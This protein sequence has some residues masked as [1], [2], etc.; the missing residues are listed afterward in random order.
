MVSDVL[1]I[2][3]LNRLQALFG[4]DKLGTRISIIVLGDFYQLKPIRAS[5]VFKSKFWLENFLFIELD[6]NWRSKD[7]PIYTALLQRIR[8]GV[9]TED[10]KLLL[11]GHVEDDDDLVKLGNQGI[12]AF[13]CTHK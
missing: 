9:L 13:C 5:F 2:A 4:S 10:D 8:V 7:D 12:P 11:A 6:Q 1:F 3:I